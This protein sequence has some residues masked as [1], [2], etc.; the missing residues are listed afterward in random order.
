M[1]STVLGWVSRRLQSSVLVDVHCVEITHQD[2]A[3]WNVK[4]ISEESQK[5]ISLRVTPRGT[6]DKDDS[7]VRFGGQFQR[8]K[9]HLWKYRAADGSI[10]SEHMILG[11]RERLIRL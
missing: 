1:C 10:W 6:I 8:S 2:E 5:G 3:E 4:E 11:C 9:H 7:Q